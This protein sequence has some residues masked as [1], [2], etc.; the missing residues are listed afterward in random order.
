[1]NLVIHIGIE[2][3]EAILARPIGNISP[4]RK[5]TDVFEIYNRGGN[6]VFGF[7]QDRSAN[8]PQFGLRPRRKDQEHEN[9][10]RS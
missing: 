5:G 4:Y 6:R 10:E 9:E 8:G 1:M 7:I 3:A 2:A